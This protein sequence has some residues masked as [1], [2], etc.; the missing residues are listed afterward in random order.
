MGRGEGT[1]YKNSPS[2][3]KKFTKF[4]CST[5]SQKAEP[6]LLLPQTITIYPMQSVRKGGSAHSS[7]LKSTQ[8]KF[9]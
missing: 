2:F 3:K 9:F 7:G 4:T 1:M 8:V 5:V 6:K